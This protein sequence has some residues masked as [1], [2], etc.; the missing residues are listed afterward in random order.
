[1]QVPARVYH[2]LTAAG[3][4]MSAACA[5]EGPTEAS[6]DHDHPTLRSERSQG[7]DIGTT[8]GWLDGQTVTLFYNKD[9]FCVNPPAAASDSGCEVGEEATV[10]PRPGSIPV[11]YVMAP[12][13]SPAPENLH[14]PV[15]GSCI[16]HPSTLDLSRIFGAE[17]GNVP[18]PPHSHVIDTRQSGWWEIEVV[19]VTDP[20]V[21][22]EVEAGKDLATVRRLQE[23]GIGITP[24]IPSNLFLFF[25]VRP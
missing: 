20:A 13:F 1:M 11:V 12:L 22:A 6:L 21:W 17:A 2:I 7:P 24:D 25:S 14:C 9:F 16:N 4:V 3:L 5:D 10:A 18:L 19:G 15:T 23:A 8:P